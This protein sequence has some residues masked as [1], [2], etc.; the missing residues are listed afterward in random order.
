MNTQTITVPRCLT[1]TLKDIGIRDV[2]VRFTSDAKGETLSFSVGEEG[3]SP[4]MICVAYEPVEQ[5]IRE[6]RR[7]KR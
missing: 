1:A 6:T 2:K 7:R 5:L 3:E 4:M